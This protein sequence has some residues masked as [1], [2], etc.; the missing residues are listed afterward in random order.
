MNLP[1]ELDALAACE[2]AA[3]TRSEGRLVW[4]TWMRGTR[5]GWLDARRSVS[6][7]AWYRHVKTLRKAGLEVPWPP[8]ED[9]DLFAPAST[10]GPYRD[11]L[12][13]LCG[14][15]FRI[16]RALDEYIVPGVTGIVRQVQFGR[17]A[18]SVGVDL[19]GSPGGYEELA[20]GVFVSA[21]EPA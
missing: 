16:T 2:A 11:S 3:D 21:T 7:S 5:G 9:A 6:R 4:V 18:W 13:K 19:D 15:P 17:D 8:H 14:M 20:L 12:L 1:P 10:L